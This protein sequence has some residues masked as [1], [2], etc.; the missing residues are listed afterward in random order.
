M[1]YKGAGADENGAPYKVELNARQVVSSLEAP[2]DI[3]YGG[4]FVS[5]PGAPSFDVE[6]IVRVYVNG[7]GVPTGASALSV[8]ASCPSF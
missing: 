5:K 1:Q 8:N 3:P 7:S 6:G 2:I 4:T